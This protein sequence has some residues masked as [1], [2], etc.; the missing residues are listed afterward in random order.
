MTTQVEG[1]TG[2]SL[3]VVKWIV[4]VV[5]LV[6][7]T[8]GNHYLTDISA[9]LRLGGVVLVALVALGLALTTA[10]GR[11]FIELLKEAR[12]EARKIVWPTRQETWQTTLI[13]GAVVIVT[14]LM[15]WGID[16]L[17]G[18]AVSAIIG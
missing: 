1:S 8:L 12:V 9:W 3:D 7:A 6:A 2:N 17:F 10:K 14:S 15:L 18:W 5:L 16:S 13:V 4:V 11:S